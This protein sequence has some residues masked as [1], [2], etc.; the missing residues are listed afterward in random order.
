MQAQTKDM[1]M[2]KI[3]IVKT[4]LRAGALLG[5]A[6]AGGDSALAQTAPSCSAT[7]TGNAG[8]GSW[9][10]AGNWSP[11]KVPGPTSDVCIPLFTQADG[12]GLDGSSLSVSVHSIQVA[13]GGAL[14]FGSGKVSI[15]TA[16][17]NQ[18]GISL[19]GTTLSAGSI[20]LPNPGNITVFN[21]SSITSP[22]FSNTTG[23]V[24]VG[25][26]GTLR[27]TDNPVQ[28]VNGNLSGGNWD[29]SSGTLI[30]PS[31]ITQITTQSGAAYDTVVS[32]DGTGSVVED[33]SGNDAL[34]TLTSV[35]PNAVLA[36]FDSASLTVAQ[37]L[38][39]QGIV[40]VSGSLTV[41][42]TYTQASGGT[43]MGGALTATSV[44]V[45]SG[46]TLSGNGT[47]VSSITN[48]GTVAPGTLTVTGNYTQ[49]GGGA[50]SEVFGSTLHVDSNAT[51]SGALN[52]TVNPKHPPKSGAMYTALTFGSL[53]GSFT[54]HTAGYTLTTTAN[55]IQV[56]KE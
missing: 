42:G 30:L 56:T 40:D 39:S 47:V 19:Y 21:N 50:L 29:V 11:R 1:S 36:L 3:H 18:G 27:L 14:L 49:T 9:S 7:W 54:S 26:G 5:V 24:Y 25:V 22:A 45:Q 12:A 52:V 33:T 46:S 13:E 17:I 31:D 44:I 55:N 51:L 43:N 37:G 2:R 6:V 15:A 10:T 41:N 48:N 38:T 34:A 4:L 23:E 16:L 35:G 28:L 32:L 20:E 53:S 8:N